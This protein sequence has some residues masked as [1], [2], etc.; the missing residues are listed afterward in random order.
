[1]K[2]KP[3]FQPVAP[4][5]PT[6]SPVRPRVECVHSFVVDKVGPLD[7][8]VLASSKYPLPVPTPSYSF[9]DTWQARLEK[10]AKATHQTPEAF[11]GGLLRRAWTGMPLK[12]RG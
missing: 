11:L 8:T 2:A 1:M 10:M 6:P 12:E 4:T 9:D 5:Q 7:V 3:P